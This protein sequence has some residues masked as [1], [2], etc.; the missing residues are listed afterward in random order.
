MNR[1]SCKYPADKK[2]YQDVWSMGV[3]LL[4]IVTGAPIWLHQKTVLEHYAPRKTHKTK[5]VKQG[6]LQINPIEEERLKSRL[7]QMSRLKVLVQTQIK[8][9]GSKDQIK[10][11]LK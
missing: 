8:M 5:L 1:S 9:F 6:A 7:Y 11:L 4:E 2:Y 3:L 10:K